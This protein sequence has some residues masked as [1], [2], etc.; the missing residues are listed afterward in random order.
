[1]F[2]ED[3]N[4]IGLQDQ[5]SEAAKNIN[6]ADF[7]LTDLMLVIH[8]ALSREAVVVQKM[9]EDFQSGDSLQNFK[10][11]FNLWASV[12]MYHADT[13]DLYM[14]LPLSDFSLARANETEHAELA[15]LAE[16]LTKYL[17]DQNSFKLEDR[18]KAAVI[19]LQQQQH[20]QILEALQG[21]LDV[22]QNEIGKTKIVARTQRH[23]YGKIVALRIS[24][25]DHFESEE[26]LVLPEVEARF[27]RE[28]KE[29]I[30]RRLLIDEQSQENA[31]VLNWLMERSDP[32]Q[33]DMLTKI[34]VG[35]N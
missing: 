26:A 28:E 29:E 18:V 1:M 32:C 2:V 27:S 33:R 24:Q 8:R 15:E 11:R 7:E 20:H 10:T 9:I 5:M 14:T 19:V 30:S 4:G 22:L 6:G 35:T 31:W 23:L 12:L 3:V 17:K 21:V 25:D 13:E 34:G 16:N